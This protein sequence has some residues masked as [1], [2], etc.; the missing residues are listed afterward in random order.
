[1]RERAAISYFFQLHPI[2]IFVRRR[3]TVSPMKLFWK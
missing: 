1:M 2:Y 3:K